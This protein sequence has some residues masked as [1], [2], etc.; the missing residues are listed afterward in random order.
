MIDNQ[1]GSIVQTINP[2][3]PTTFDNLITHLSDKDRPV[4]KSAVIALG[5]TGD[6]RVIEPLIFAL[7]RE[8][9]RDAGSYPVIIEI[10]DA[11]AKI[12]D[13]RAL[14]ALVKVESQ[15][16]DRDSPGCPAGLPSGVIT[17]HDMGDGHVRR[18]VPRELHFKVLDVMRRIGHRLD[19]Q[20][21]E[22]T[23]RYLAYQDEVIQAELD[24]K[25]PELARMLQDYASSA[26]GNNAVAASVSGTGDDLM[27]GAPPESEDAVADIDYD[28]LRQE[29]EIEVSRYVR[30]N[31]RLQSLI[32]DGQRIKAHIQHANQEK[33]K[34]DAVRQPG[35]VSVR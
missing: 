35:R 31:E 13:R 4:R 15:L 34:Y 1:P 27:A 9:T 30:D 32:R 33:A 22:I 28:V 25:M 24:R 14:D 11:M 20:A 10:L 2:I 18:A 23:A 16:V 6:A 5:N 26:N 3:S 19:Y 17:F 29:M 7:S 8:L 21:D 12:P